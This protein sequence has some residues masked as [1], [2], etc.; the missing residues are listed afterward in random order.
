MGWQAKLMLM[1]WLFG[2]IPFIAPLL[3]P[4]AFAAAA[5]PEVAV[6]AAPAA[7]TEAT[8]EVF[9]RDIITFRA[10]ALG[11][12]PQDRAR[13]AKI[14]IKEQLHA[15]G[16]HKV[17]LQTNP[18][19][20]LVQIDGAMSFLVIADDVDKLQQESLADAAGK[21]AVALTAAIDATREG[22]SLDAIVRAVAVSTAITLAAFALLWAMRRVRQAVERWLVRV[23]ERHAERL[24]VS[25]VQLLHRERLAW[26]AH[27]AVVVL[28]TVLTAVILYEWISLVF[29]Q[30][31]Y[32]RVWSERLTD[33]LV[34][35]VVGIGSGIADAMPGLFVAV[36]IFFIARSASRLLS[37]FF[38]RVQSGQVQVSWLD[39]D[40]AMLTRRIANALL[41]L[42]ALAMAYPYLPGAHTEAFKGLSVLVGLMLSLGASNLVGQAESGLILTYSHVYRHGEYVRIAEHEGTVTELGMFATRLRTGLGE[43][44]TL[45][46]S[47]ILGAVTR[48]Y[49]RAVKGPGFVLD[50]VA[51]IGYDTPWRQVHAMLVEAALRTPGV[52]AEPPPRVFQ[53]GLSDFYPEYRLVCQAIPSEPMPRA[54]VLSTLHA[55][56]QDVFNEYGVQIMSPHY[57]EDP[58]APKTVPKEHWFTA[59]ARPPEA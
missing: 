18:L 9:N 57:L 7:S 36:V 44:L 46:N 6:G 2:L 30:F 12:S 37:G 15:P 38:D 48:N 14:R 50:T 45:S 47:L 34:A 5:E 11:I 13:R 26:L 51:T 1:R 40:V 56:I 33:F 24:R 29:A 31:P 23:T 41:W 25:G 53:T 52:L 32:T 22:R 10:P 39:T 16:A 3:A 59:P 19:G 27:A 20:T 35:T 21:A 54:V 58:A 49:S 4:N 8:L 55:N 42:F 28:Q 43:E 17:T